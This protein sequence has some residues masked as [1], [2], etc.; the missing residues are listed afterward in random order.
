M[1]LFNRT[2]H[3]E[4]RPDDVPFPKGLQDA[5]AWNGFWRQALGS[6]DYVHL[7]LLRLPPYQYQ[8]INFVHSLDERNLRRVLFVGNG[9]SVLPYLFAHAGFEAFALDISPVAVEYSVANPPAETYYLQFFGPAPSILHYEP[10]P[11]EH[12]GLA[13]VE[14][15][16]Q[17]LNEAK[18]DGGS[19]HF[20]VASLFEFE[21]ER[22]FDAVVCVNVL[23]HLADADLPAAVHQVSSWLRPGGALLADGSVSQCL[24]SSDRLRDGISDAYVATVFRVF[25]EAGFEV[26]NKASI[27]SERSEQ[28]RRGNPFGREEQAQNGALQ[29]KESPQTI[30]DKTVILGVPR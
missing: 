25:E 16:R 12:L 3:F 22:L 23:D 6:A 7:R 13:R 5:P 30:R 1:T 17:K 2:V 21:P 10:N 26:I 20:E 29:A 19:V 9:V 28:V 15:L 24:R 14:R 18:R 27:L 8:Y 11:V 4:G